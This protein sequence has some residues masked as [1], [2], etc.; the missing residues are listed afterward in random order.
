MYTTIVTHTFCIYIFN[1]TFIFRPHF[2]YL[3]SCLARCYCISQLSYNSCNHLT[4]SAAAPTHEVSIYRVKA[5]VPTGGSF[6]CHLRKSL[7]SQHRISGAQP[8][9]L[10]GSW[11]LCS[12]SFEKSTGCSTFHWKAIRPK[13]RPVPQHNPVSD[14]C[15]AGNSS[16]LIIWFFLWCAKSIVRPYMDK[17]YIII[18]TQVDCNQ[19]EKIS[20]RWSREMWGKVFTAQAPKI[21]T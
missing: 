10:S 3:P 5:Q 12:A 16:H 7:T 15:S 18:F 4:A 6:Y 1:T 9:R 11:S 8:D 14:L 21:L 19:D 17:S 13:S 2:S 20:Y